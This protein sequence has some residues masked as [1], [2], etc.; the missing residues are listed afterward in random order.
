MARVSHDSAAYW[1]RIALVGSTHLVAAAVTLY[2]YPDKIELL[3]EVSAAVAHQQMHP[4]AEPLAPG[5]SPLI[6]LRH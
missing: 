4:E 1:L 3:A 6:G 2:Q 5:E